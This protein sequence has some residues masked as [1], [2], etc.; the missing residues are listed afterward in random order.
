MSISHKNGDSM[1]HEYLNLICA[2]SV[3]LA[4]AN[5][6]KMMLYSKVDKKGPEQGVGKLGVPVSTIAA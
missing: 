5:C 3:Y 4:D 1:F 6:V 2:K